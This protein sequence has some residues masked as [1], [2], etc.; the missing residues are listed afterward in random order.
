MKMTYFELK[1]IFSKPVNKIVLLLLAITLCITSYFAIGSVVYVD[2]N[3]EESTGIA[4]ASALQKAKN[5]W[6][7]YITDDVLRKGLEENALMINSEEYLSTD[8]VENNK[9]Y[10][11]R[12]GFSDIRDLINLAFCDFQEYNYF[13]ADSVTQEE[14]GSFYGRRTA[15]LMEWLNSDEQEGR[16]SDQEKQ[17]LIT[18]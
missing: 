16:F 9:A 13:R 6:A 1:K 2:E 8:V 3:G 18:Q 17:F 4:A 10:S 5:E 7:G 15:T 12:Q 11:K 14:I